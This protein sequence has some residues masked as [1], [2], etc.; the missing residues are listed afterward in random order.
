MKAT[1]NRNA[2]IYIERDGS[3]W[4]QRPCNVPGI[5]NYSNEPETDDLGVG[6]YTN[7]PP[8]EGFGVGSYTNEGDDQ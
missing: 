6:S 8:S 5:G 3:V 1:V 4:F 2:I 7:V